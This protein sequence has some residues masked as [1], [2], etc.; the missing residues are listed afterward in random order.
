MD[1][2]KSVPHNSVKA[3]LISDMRQEM[4]AAV[5][6]ELCTESNSQVC[7]L[8]HVFTA[9]LHCPTRI[10]IPGLDIRP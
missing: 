7:E 8:Q 6:S 9:D 1:L 3:S 2:N 4:A 5:I 10:P